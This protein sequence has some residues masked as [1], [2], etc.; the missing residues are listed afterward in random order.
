MVGRVFPVI[1]R[2]VLG[3]VALLVLIVGAHPLAAHGILQRSSPRANAV[4]PS[5][6][7]RLV[8]EFNESVEPRFSR[9][10]V[11]G[12]GGS[13]LARGGETSGDGRR[14]SLS[15]EGS[16]AGIYA[17]RWR[18]LSAVDGHT[19]SGSFLFAVGEAGAPPPSPSPRPPA[20]PPLGL[21]AARW[22]TYLSALLLSGAVL[23]D[24]AVLHR[25]VGQM[26]P[27][28]RAVV[29]APASAAVSRLR[30][31][32][33]VVL[34]LALAVE[35]VVQGADVL[36]AGAG[37]MLR[38]NVISTLLVQTKLGWSTLARLFATVLLLL[39][40]GPSGRILRAAGLIWLGVFTA[41][42]AS[43]GGPSALGSSHVALIVLVGAVYGLASILAA[44]IVPAIPD[45]RVPAWRAAAPLAAGVLLAG[46]TIA[47]HA[48]GRGGL[49]AVFDWLHLTAAAAWVGGLP[50]L[51]LTLRAVPSP[52]RSEIGRLLVPRVS[53]VAGLSLLVLILTGTAASWTFVASLRGFIDTTY[54]RSL[55][56]K[57]ALV[58]IVAFLGAVNRFV[59]SPRIAS[60]DI[61]ALERFRRSVSLEAV[62]GAL[63]LLVVAALG[64][65]PPAAV[66]PAPSP[67]AG[68]LYAGDLAGSRVLV[69]VTPGTAGLND[70]TVEGGRAS[71]RL[72]HLGTFREAALSPDGTVELTD[73]WWEIVVT[74]GRAQTI[75]PL[76]VGEPPAGSD[77]AAVRDLAR[78]RAV[79]RRV[80]TWREVE[81]ITDG[82]GHAVETQFEAVRPNRLRYRTTSGSEAVIIGAVRL[83]RDRGAPWLRDLLPQPMQLDGPY[84]QYLEGA[85]AVRFGGEESCAGEI[86]RIVLWAL[87]AGRAQFAA[88]IGRRSSRIYGIE[89]VAPAHY[90]TSRA[91][92][93]NAPLVITPP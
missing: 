52:A 51:A 28:G 19:A 9:V 58:L 57:L 78:A 47:S 55:A 26:D 42:T 37:G 25:A 16:G 49:L 24:A 6:P 34:L 83:S 65:M 81:R 64:I 54:G 72:R 7:E 46:F 3:S 77:P 14:L 36:G 80:R 15:L 56:A 61:R 82:S 4:L 63:I 12:P 74:G 40:D 10:E 84:A 75:F 53:A 44:R 91:D 62:L 27:A 59:L 35:F 90:M 21:V 13:V 88:R 23:F 48:G 76:V 45:L 93:L 20:L 18:V 79:M 43:L 32:S 68:V 17:V 66:T 11:V 87:P 22:L 30:M 29:G 85:T 31:I 71:V 1:R 8:L 86:C 60:R 70:V 33:A 50:A 41:V 38:R 2:V 67:A 69:R 73:G 89:M 92:R 5:P 39:P